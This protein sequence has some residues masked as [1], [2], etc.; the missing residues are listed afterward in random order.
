MQ[1]SQEIIVRATPLAVTNRRFLIGNEPSVG[2][3]HSGVIAPE[4]GTRVDGPGRDHDGRALRDGLIADT[5]VADSHA[6]G[7]GDGREEAEDFAAYGVQISQ[8]F[9]CIC[10]HYRG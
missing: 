6:D 1:K 10:R 8:L 7:D 4:C 3:E 5:C 9:D 2:T